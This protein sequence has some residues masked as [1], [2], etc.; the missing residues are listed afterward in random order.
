MTEDLFDIERPRRVAK[1][2]TGEAKE[3]SEVETIVLRV[4]VQPAAG[5]SSVAGRHGDALKLRV[6][7]PPV[8]DRANQACQEAIAELLGVSRSQ[9]E[10]VGG[11]TSRSK[12]IRVSGVEV[13]ETRR[14]LARAIA[15]AG[16]PGG[17]RE[18]PPAR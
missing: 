15:E 16:S 7:A 8:K 2:G 18:R 3:G 12:R 5:R 14:R 17:P 1:S 4:H 13:E 10:L 11:S 6:A 9:V